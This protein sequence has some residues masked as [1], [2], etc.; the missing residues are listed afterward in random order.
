MRLKTFES[1]LK[2]Q[3][4][5]LF[6]NGILKDAALY[7]LFPGGKR[8][9]PGFVYM[10]GNAAR[11]Q[12]SKLDKLACAIELIHNYTLI[13]DDLPAMDNDDYRRGKLT[14]HKKFG[15]ACAILTG[16]A[17]L[18]HALELVGE[19]A[20]TKVMELVARSIGAKGIIEGQIRDLRLDAG[21]KTQDARNIKRTYELKTC[22]LFEA[23]MCTPILLST[24][25]NK[26]RFFKKSMEFAGK[27]GFCFQLADDLDDMKQDTKQHPAI[28]KNL[29][30]LL[31]YKKAKNILISELNI[32]ERKLQELP[33]S[34]S[35][36]QKLAGYI[37]KMRN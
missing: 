11:V 15:Q 4:S 34:A 30:E 10:F 14:V 19:T 33:I 9:R 27:F 22:R 23:A 21:R 16:D 28:N 37:L 32:L 13:H 36:R 12:K 24:N 8:L 25:K 35:S 18:T 5:R 1:T 2:K 31:G 26:Q 7:A 6:A 17:L 20:D 3:V 29:A